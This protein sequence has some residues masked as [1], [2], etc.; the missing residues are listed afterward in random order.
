MKRFLSLFLTLVL[1]LSFTGCK[2]HDALDRGKLYTLQEAFDNGYITHE[3]LLVIAS[4]TKNL[5][6]CPKIKDTRIEEQIKDAGA[7]RANALDLYSEE[8]TGDDMIIAHFFGEYS[9]AYVVL[10]YKW[11][12]I[13]TSEEWGEIK[14]D[15]VSIN[16]LSCLVD[17]FLVWKQFEE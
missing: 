4:Y 9:G 6:A 16:M 3:D 17:Y 8:V 1:L 12:T 7:K 10:V 13:Y 14:V 11:N 15:G 5:S 2:G